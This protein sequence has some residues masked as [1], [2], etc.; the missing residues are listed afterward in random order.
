MEKIKQ[1]EGLRGI[2]ALIVFF[3]HFQLFCFSYDSL[4]FE[5]KVRNSGLPVFLQQFIQEAK[6]LLHN[7]D[8]AVWLFW[9]LSAF[10][11][12]RILF[13]A[14]PLEET[15]VLFRSFSKRY[16]RLLIP[17]AASVIL[18]VILV[19]SKLMFNQDVPAMLQDTGF[20]QNWIGRYY[21][22]DFGLG[23]IAYFTFYEVFFDF[24]FKQALNPVLWTINM[25]FLGSL[26]VFC[27][28]GLLRKN[29]NRYYFYVLIVIPLL[30]MGVYWSVPFLLG[31]VL[32]DLTINPVQLK[33]L[34]PLTKIY[35]KISGQTLL[36]LLFFVILLVMSQAMLKEMGLPKGL[37]YTVISSF[38]LFASLKNEFL[39]RFFSIQFNQWLG[40]ISFSLYLIHFLL[41][42]SFSAYLLT[43]R[44]DFNFRLC[45]CFLTLGF[46]L[47]L[48][49]FFHKFVDK[50]AVLLA[51]KFG[52]FV[53]RKQ[54]T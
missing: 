9:T 1:L 28:F 32:S 53:S 46:S 35:E 25:E 34:K 14:S 27:L 15:E 39:I 10:V 13:K 6:L 43:I 31:Y 47:L 51:N 3:H 33:T 22:F 45:V 23:K 2:A 52:T 21:N 17:V 38:I 41:I 5:S 12:S 7:G 29:P 48:A 4:V 20:E 36:L 42:C 24:D 16:I 18:A 30:V 26:F 40:K 37:Q 11:L 44:S 49:H 50:S 19:K 8:L 54:G